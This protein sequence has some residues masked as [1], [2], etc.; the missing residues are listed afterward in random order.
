[1][2]A[3]PLRKWWRSA[4]RARRRGLALLTPVQLPFPED[5]ARARLARYRALFALMSKTVDTVADTAST[6]A[7]EPVEALAVVRRHV[8]RLRFDLAVLDSEVQS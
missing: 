2:T 3:S 1:M 6:G 5:A 7:L 8:K 4:A